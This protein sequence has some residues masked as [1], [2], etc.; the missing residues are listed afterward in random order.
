MVVYNGAFS[1]AGNVEN[2]SGL[3]YMFCVRPGSRYIA[4]WPWFLLVRNQI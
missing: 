3:I 2:I 1:K 4:K